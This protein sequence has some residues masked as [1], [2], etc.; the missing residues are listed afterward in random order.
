MGTADERDLSWR[1]KSH[2]KRESWRCTL[3][4][5]LFHVCLQW[6][7]TQLAVQTKPR[8]PHNRVPPAE[9]AHSEQGPK[10]LSKTQRAA[11]G[12]ARHSCCPRGMCWEDAGGVQILQMKMLPLPAPGM[13][14]ST[15]FPACFRT[16][17]REHATTT[18][19]QENIGGLKTSTHALKLK[20]DFKSFKSLLTAFKEGTFSQTATEKIAWVSLLWYRE[21]PSSF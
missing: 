20:K 12:G 19:R 3:N 14:G 5:C 4:Y 9:L 15:P 8:K 17:E 18:Y 1:K 7:S 11:T 6:I 16:I 21:L 2:A 10:K 13:E